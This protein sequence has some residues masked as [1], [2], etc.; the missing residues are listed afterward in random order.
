MYV[1][2]CVSP[3]LLFCV[4]IFVLLRFVISVGMSFIATCVFWL[5]V[6]MYVCV[7]VQACNLV[8]L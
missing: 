5:Q 1:C 7:C 3:G 4:G 2:V 6:F 8:L